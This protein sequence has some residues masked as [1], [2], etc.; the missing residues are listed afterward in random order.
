MPPP[1]RKSFIDLRAAASLRVRMSI[2]RRAD[3]DLSDGRDTAELS[4]DVLPSP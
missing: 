2:Q 3:N 4:A 1:K